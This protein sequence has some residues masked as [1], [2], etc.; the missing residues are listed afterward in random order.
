LRESIED[1]S[2]LLPSVLGNSETLK[3]SFWLVFACYFKDRCSQDG[4]FGIRKKLKLLD[5]DKIFHVSTA[6]MV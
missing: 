4:Y 5:V 1:A 6:E 2:K 3:S